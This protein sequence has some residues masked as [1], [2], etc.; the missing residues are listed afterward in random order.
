MKREPADHRATV[1]AKS[2]EGCAPDGARRGMRPIGWKRVPGRVQFHPSLG[3]VPADSGAV[4][5][6]LDSE[7][8]KALQENKFLPVAL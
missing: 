2:C 7:G 8:L 6:T 4:E 1:L 5:F 3:V